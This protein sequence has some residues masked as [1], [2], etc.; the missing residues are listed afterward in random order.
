LIEPHVDEGE[1]RRHRRHE[2]ESTDPAQSHRLLPS[3]GEAI[4]LPVRSIWGV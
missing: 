3:T 2:D 1:E 4:D